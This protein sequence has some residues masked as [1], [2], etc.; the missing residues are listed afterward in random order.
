MFKHLCSS[1]LMIAALLA[2]AGCATAA[3]PDASSGSTIQLDPDTGQV[4]QPSGHQS[5]ANRSG[6]Q[7]THDDRASSSSDRDTTAHGHVVHCADGSLHMGATGQGDDDSD[8]NQRTL[9]DKSAD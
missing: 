5:S 3:D 2:M 7:K 8:P 1:G 6:G 4:I 9:C